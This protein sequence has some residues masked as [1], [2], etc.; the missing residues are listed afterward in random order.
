MWLDLEWKYSF[1]QCIKMLIGLLSRQEFLAY[2]YQKNI[3]QNSYKEPLLL[4]EI[5]WVSY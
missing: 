3:S 5:T 4:R 2:I 1:I